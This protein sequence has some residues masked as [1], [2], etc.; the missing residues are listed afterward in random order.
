MQRFSWENITI[1]TEERERVVLC[2]TELLETVRRK[3]VEYA[4]SEGQKKEQ[5]ENG[6][7]LRQALSDYLGELPAEPLSVCY[8][9]YGK[10]YLEDGRCFYSLSHSEELLVCAVSDVEVGADVE[11]CRPLRQDISRKILSDAEYESYL[12]LPEEEKNDWLIR[13]WTEK[14]SIGKLLGTGIR[15]PKELDRTEFALRTWKRDGAW[16]TA[17]KR[18]TV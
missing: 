13:V 11:V 16:L 7:F 5:R 18:R 15:T 9:C 3:K 10:P 4:R 6:A 1:Y 14:E 17:A 2:P 12:R 8:N